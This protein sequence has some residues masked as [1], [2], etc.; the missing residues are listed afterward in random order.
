MACTGLI[1]SVQAAYG[2]STIPAKGLF[3]ELSLVTGLAGLNPR[4]CTMRYVT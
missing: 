2:K 1:T 3:K 4:I